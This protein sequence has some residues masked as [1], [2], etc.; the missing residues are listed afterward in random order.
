MATGLAIMGFGGGALIG[1]P[2]A[3]KLM[4]NYPLDEAFFIIGCIDLLA[5]MVGAFAY[6]VPPEGWKPQGWEPTI[7]KSSSAMSLM[8]GYVDANKAVKTPQFWLLWCCLCMNVSC[9]L[10][11]LGQTSLLVQDMAGTTAAVAVRR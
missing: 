7:T 3:V 1:A 10:A 5:M 9:G 8:G 4:Q 11:I 6:R 2:L